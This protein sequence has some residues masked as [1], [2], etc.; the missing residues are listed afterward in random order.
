MFFWWKVVFVCS[1]NHWFWSLKFSFCFVEVDGVVGHSAKGSGCESRPRRIC[2]RI[3]EIIKCTVKQVNSR[4]F[5][6]LMGDLVAANNIQ[7]RAVGKNWTIK[8][9]CRD[10]AKKIWLDRTHSTKKS[11]R[12]LPQ[13]IRMEPARKKITWTPQS[14]LEAH[15]S[16]GMRE[17]IIWRTTS[18]SQEPPPIES[19]S[20]WPMLHW[21]M[22]I[23]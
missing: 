8:N 23:K 10:K 2:K 21:S 4:Q 12:N 14:H 13:R 18:S 19:E 16:G 15:C 3:L 22:A 1:P 11:K 17:N 7:P 20:W 5:L 6:A 9:R